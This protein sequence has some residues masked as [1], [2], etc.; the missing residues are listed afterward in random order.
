MKV[1]E[2]T[3]ESTQNKQ[4]IIERFIEDGRRFIKVIPFHPQI[5]AQIKETFKTK[6]VKV[7]LLNNGWIFIQKIARDEAMEEASKQ[8]I[9]D[10]DISLREMI[11]MEAD[12]LRKGKFIVKIEEKETENA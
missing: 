10:K 11:D 4:R 1:Y 7:E 2:L 9:G 8:V 5:F 12:F 6:P 3:A